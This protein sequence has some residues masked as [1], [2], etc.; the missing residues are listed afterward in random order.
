MTAAIFYASDGY[1]VGKDKIMGRQVAGNSFLKGYFKYTNCNEFWV[2]SSTQME[3]D[4]FTKMAREEGR[5]ED[6]K[7]INFKNTSALTQPGILFYPGPDIFLQAHNRSFFGNNFWSLC[8]ITHT[9]ST[10]AVIESIQAL[11]TKPVNTWDALICTS[12]AVQSNIYNIIEMEEEN[13][14]RKLNATKF[15][16]PQ[17][18]IIP[19]GINYSEFQFTK[20]QKVDARK[21][22]SIKDD[23]IVILYVGR[24][25][26]H[27]KSNPFPMYKAIAQVA[28]RSNKKLV[29]IE[30]G[31]YGNQ[32][33]EDSFS[34]AAKYLC[35][36]I[37]IIKVDGRE[38]HLRMKSFASANIFCSLSDNVQE[39]F[40][41]TPIEAMASGLPVIA[42]DWNGYKDTVRNEIDGFLI[43][44]LMP[45]PG[46]G[47]DL[48]ARY[49]LG[50]DDYDIYIGNVSNFIS[51]NFSALCKALDSLINNE[52][53]RLEM[54]LNGK[55]RVLGEFD[56][57]K[58][59]PKYND[60]WNELDSCRLSS[61]DSHKSWSI[62][63]DPYYAFSSYPT[64]TINNNS[65]ISFVE[66][67]RDLTL[68]RIKEIKSLF[69][70]SYSKYTVPN[71]RIL[72]QIIDNTPQEGV[73]FGTLKDNLK[74][75]N[76]IYLRRC[77]LWMNKFNVI[78]LECK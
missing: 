27:A 30:C 13:L 19:L 2:Y 20:N 8:G 29:L 23:E 39:T 32:G 15:D 21:E 25:S 72:I 7:F 45:R 16:R 28:K 63:L 11:V 33:I 61:F 70:A 26:F 42:S 74:K 40:G 24:L 71:D 14:R 51:V 54:G 12:K 31:W 41:I 77:L 53:L 35:D 44:T 50:I 60:L 10:R 76:D 18:P 56:W 66:N 52:N 49:A 22:F 6:V 5:N 46:D 34:E 17:L 37:R 78:N 68:Q 59:L 48:A 62:K 67:N 55:K 65:V 57:S 58:I 47:L 73:S 1:Q 9:T 64:N 43:P 4:K 3:A 69:I 36:G 38:N 75:I